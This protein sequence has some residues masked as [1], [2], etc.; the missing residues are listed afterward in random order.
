MFY[1]LVN[2]ANLATAIKNAKEGKW[3]LIT[4]IQY[5]IRYCGGLNTLSGSMTR[6]MGVMLREWYVRGRAAVM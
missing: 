3:N 5:C 2:L 4:K 6:R 1:K